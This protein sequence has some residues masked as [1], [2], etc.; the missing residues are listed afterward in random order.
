MKTSAV[1]VNTSRSGVIDQTALVAALQRGQIMGAALDVFD[2]E[3]LPPD[4]PL[5][6]LDNVT[7]TSHMAGST[8]D[9]FS[10]SPRLF[11]DRFIAAH[12]ELF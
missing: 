12:P 6:K 4:D 11:V 9:A 10:N 8:V 1:L 3:P 7:L 5:L 2:V